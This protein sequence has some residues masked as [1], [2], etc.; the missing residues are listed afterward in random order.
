[1]DDKCVLKVVCDERSSSI[2]ETTN[3]LEKKSEREIDR[4]EN[5]TNSLFDKIDVINDTFNGNDTREGVFESIRN[6]SAS[7]K[8]LKELSQISLKI[9][10]VFKI[11][12]ITIITLI[13]ISILTLGGSAA[14]FKLPKMF[15]DKVVYVIKEIFFVPE[16][17]QAEEIRIREIIDTYL[18]EKEDQKNNLIIP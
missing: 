18:Q 15:K 10:K 16:R 5:E 14:G 8:E 6:I 1:M 9:K 17:I 7:E 4:I 11:V 2:K 12:K 13:T 3:R